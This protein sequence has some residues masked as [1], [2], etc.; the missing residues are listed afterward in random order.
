[1][2]ISSLPA[3][4]E[5][6]VQSEIA[7]G[8]FSSV[9]ELVCEALRQYQERQSR[10]THLRQEIQLGLDDLDCGE[11]I[12]IHDDAELDAYFDGL[13]ARGQERLSNPHGT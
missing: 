13:V 5:R 9:E 12:E 8:R 2:L 7:S 3:E 10:L 1:M 11:R 6:M 4:F